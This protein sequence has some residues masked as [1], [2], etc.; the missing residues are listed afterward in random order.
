MIFLEKLVV[1]EDLKYM[2]DWIV[3]QQIDG[4]I[5]AIM[6]QTVFFFNEETAI[7]AGY[8]PCAICMPEEYSQWKGNSLKLSK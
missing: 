8:R 4:L 2:V 7:E 3:P 1:I 5:K 6:Y